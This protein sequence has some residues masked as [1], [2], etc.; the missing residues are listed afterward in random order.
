MPADVGAVAPLRPLD[1][2][3]FGRSNVFSTYPLFFHTLAHSFAPRA[4]CNSF[5]INSLRTLSVI[6]GGVYP[7]SG[8]LTTRISPLFPS[9]CGRPSHGTSR[10]ETRNV[11]FFRPVTSK[12]ARFSVPPL[13]KTRAGLPPASSATSGAKFRASREIFAVVPRTRTV[14]PRCSPAFNGE[15][16]ASRS[17]PTSVRENGRASSFAQEISTLAPPGPTSEGGR[18]TKETGEE[19]STSAG[20]PAIRT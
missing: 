8:Q 20:C 2:Q 12:R 11:P 1:V 7:S 4:L 9:H 15:E 3:T 6:T 17:S 5:G 10:I 13:L 14:S 19:A 18:I 16:S